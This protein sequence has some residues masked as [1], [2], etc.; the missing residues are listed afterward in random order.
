M[1][2][3]GEQ[4]TAV[5]LVDKLTKNGNYALWR[6]KLERALKSQK[7][8]DIAI[9]NTNAPGDQATV[10]ERSAYSYNID[11]CLYIITRGIHDEILQEYIRLETPKQLLD[12]LEEQFRSKAT[13]NKILL[14]KQLTELR[15]TDGDDL[16]AHMSA[17]DKIIKDL[18]DIG[19]QTDDSDAWI[20][21]LISVSHA[22]SY[23]SLCTTLEQLPGMTYAKL[24]EAFKNE[25]HK[26]KADGKPLNGA[27]FTHGGGKGSGGGQPKF[28]GRN[29]GK[30][31]SNNN[32][33]GGGGNGNKSNLTCNFCDKKGHMEKNCHAKQAAMKAAKEATASKA[34]GSS[35]KS[36]SSGNTK[37]GATPA[38]VHES[39][40]MFV[41]SQTALI[42]GGEG[43]W[44]LDTCATSHMCC[45]WE[46][47]SSLTT[48]P[49]IP[50]MVGGK[51]TLQCTQEGSIPIN[52]IVDG[53]VVQ[54]TLMKVLFVPTL[55]VNLISYGKAMI[56]GISI[57]SN[58]PDNHLTLKRGEKVIAYADYKDDIFILQ[59]SV[60]YS[61]KKSLP[62]PMP[63]DIWAE[64]VQR[65]YIAKSNINDV[66]AMDVW[67]ERLGHISQE[68]IAQMGKG[69]AVGVHNISVHTPLNPCYAC[70]VGKFHKEFRSRAPASRATKLLQLIHSDVFGPMG[71][72]S[73]GKSLYFVIFIDDHSRFGAIYFMAHKDEVL[74]H[75]KT[76]YKWACTQKG[77]LILRFRADNAGDYTSLSFVAFI[78]KKGIQSE[79][80]TPHSPHQN[81]VAERRGRSIIEIAR[82]M[83]YHA[84]LSKQW[85]A[86]AC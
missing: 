3:A 74:S 17:Y 81:G 67:H 68:R 41:T 51:G 66:N 52:F 29:K 56:A 2:A 48:I 5:V 31:S 16:S 25:H 21:L 61:R 55:G 53:Q 80:S 18:Q 20:G 58:H 69:A 14:K 85:W 72:Q 65:A 12:A 71:T 49:P 54:E 13:V 46:Y 82:C 4:T 60:D 59:A 11:R 27:L 19:V 83:L 50:I 70:T 73:I 76:Y 38:K 86:H 1:A 23:K 22:E 36:G 26:R 84:R 34:S 7:L 62:K 24:R 43:K 63:S 37:G 6:Y 9:G 32:N 40:Q 35:Q 33:Q 79:L 75:F 15:F 42:A 64:G 45:R 30:G 77:A 47:F 28:Q 39:H 10:D 8:W 44:F 78:A 57:H